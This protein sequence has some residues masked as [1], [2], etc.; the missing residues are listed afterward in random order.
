MSR[1]Y[2]GEVAELR[3]QLGRLTPAQI[4]ATPD[5]LRTV[6]AGFN[7]LEERLAE[8]PRVQRDAVMFL[9]CREAVPI[10]IRLHMLAAG[11]IY[12]REMQGCRGQDDARRAFE[13]R[14]DVF[15]EL[16]EMFE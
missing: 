8:L 9:F 7:R 4:A 5:R 16:A 6:Q 12:S 10:M 1:D 13:A 3:H 11:L 2:H 15:R 14:F